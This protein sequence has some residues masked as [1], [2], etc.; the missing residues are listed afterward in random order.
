MRHSLTAMALSA[1]LVAFLVFAGMLQNVFAPIPLIEQLQG[2]LDPETKLYVGMGEIVN[3]S[4]DSYPMGNVKLD[5]EFQGDN[6]RVHYSEPT[7]TNLLPVK[8]G[9][10]I[11][12]GMALPFVIVL[13]DT[14]LSSKVKSIEDVAS[15]TGS[16]TWKPADLVVTPGQIHSI[17]ESEFDGVKYKTWAIEG[18]ILNNY[19]QPTTHVYVVAGIHE[20]YRLVGV[21]GYSQKDKQPLTLGGMEKKNFTLYATMPAN[22]NPDRVNFLAESDDSS[23]MRDNYLPILSKYSVNG[24][25]VGSVDNVIIDNKTVTFTAELSNFARKDVDFDVVFQVL[26]VPF[27]GQYGNTINDDLLLQQSTTADLQ[28]LHSSINALGT[29]TVDYSWTAD[30]G[31]YY[32]YA[33]YVVNDLDSPKMLSKPFMYK[34]SGY[35]PR[36]LASDMLHVK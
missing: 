22:V 26:K 1:A 16:G 14:S 17:S 11:P 32:A 18:T 13:N 8:G 6:G 29:A 24:V 19:T 10:S 33:I 35:P 9:F 5:L 3:Y 31:G 15:Q 20:G 25:P 2:Y 36:F 34:V 30:S 23:M 7:V 4:A 28:V 12:P 21:A 27:S